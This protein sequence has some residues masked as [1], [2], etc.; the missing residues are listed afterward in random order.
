MMI[1]GKED[2]IFWFLFGRLPRVYRADEIPRFD[3]IDAEQFALQNLDLPITSG[4]SVKFGDV[5][6]N[7]VRRTLVP[8]EEANY[9]HWTWGR[10]ACLGDSIHKM[11]PNSGSGGNAAIESAAALANVIYSLS[12]YG[13]CRPDLNEISRA[14]ESY[15]QSRKFRASETI[16]IAHDLTR[17]HALKGMKERIIARYILPMAGD[18][19]ADLGTDGWIGATMLDY[20]PPPPRSLLGTMPFN[21]SQGLGKHE[22]LLRRSV[23]ALPLLI[24][25]VWCFA[26]MMP[27]LPL[28]QFLEI[29]EEGRIS[30]G[31]DSSIPVL[32]RLFHIPFL[33]GILQRAALVLVPSA[34]NIDPAS[35]YQAFTLMVDSGAIYAIMLIEGTRGANIFKPASV[36]FIFGL[37]STHGIGVFFP[38]YYFLYYTLT[39]IATFAALD[40]RLTNRAFTLSV[41]PVLAAAYYAP[42]FLAYCAPDLRLRY[43]AV[44]IW[45][46][47]PIWATIGQHILSWTVMP[48]TRTL[49]RFQSPTRDLMAIRITAGTL[50]ALS[51]AIWVYTLISGSV[52]GLLLP[53]SPLPASPGANDVYFS[54][55]RNLLIWDHVSFASSSLLWVVYLF[56][57][58]RRA[59]LVQHKWAFLVAG[60]AA[61][62]IVVGVGATTTLAWLWR[63]EILASKRHK[64]AVVK[65][66]IDIE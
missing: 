25:G 6:E 60:L 35:S 19:L 47:F 8:V 66:S 57:D 12:K 37:L 46:L 40:K 2:R 4:C 29:L 30:W 9:A 27:L 20:L 41:L 44:W 32:K 48:Q 61:S 55:V 24:L 65:K 28:D 51:G 26:T 38:V 21:P 52:A 53:Q 43:Y 17:I 16:K 33:D 11:T 45:H 39:P 54:G 23:I 3:E 59:G 62:S 49:D 64:D 14:L 31:Q 50:A 10:F 13:G 1:V 36:P 22:S 34:L 63:E 7:R 58:L 15:Q 42:L 18:V 56:S 5:W